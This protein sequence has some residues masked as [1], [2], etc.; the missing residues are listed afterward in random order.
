[1]IIMFKIETEV[2]TELCKQSGTVIATGGGCVTI[3]EN[4]PILRQNS[5]VIWLLRDLAQLPTDGRPLSQSADLQNMYNTRKPLYEKACDLQIL[6]NQ[7][8]EQVAE[9]IIGRISERI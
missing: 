2:L 1:M 3:E 6:N 5:K 9:D 4:I 8:P 7:P